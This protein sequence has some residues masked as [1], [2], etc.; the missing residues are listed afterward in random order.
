MNFNIPAA[1][2]LPEQQAESKIS[3][4]ADEI[5]KDL[6]KSQLPQITSELEQYLKLRIL[7]E[8]IL[9]KD[10]PDELRKEIGTRDP[11][12]EFLARVEGFD[13][14]DALTDEYGFT[15]DS[16]TPKYTIG[17]L[18]ELISELKK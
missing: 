17:E 18:K 12:D 5:K 1:P 6:P 14:W 15:P 3:K 2:K 16:N 10:L 13:L 4:R 11:V 9:L 7:S 8:T